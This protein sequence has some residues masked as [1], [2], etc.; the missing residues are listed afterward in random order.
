[1]LTVAPVAISPGTAS[2]PA[3]ALTSLTPT[4]TWSAVT[5]VN[6]YQVRVLN[7]T[8]GVYTLT[9]T[10][11]ATVT[12]Y[13]VPSGMLLPGRLFAW[14]VRDVIGKTP[15]ASSG[16]LNFGTPVPPA[17]VAAPLVGTGSATRPVLSTLRPTLAWSAVANASGYVLHVTDDETGLVITE[18][19]TARDTSYTF[20]TD[21]LVPGH[22]FDWNVRDVIGTATARTASN[23]EHFQL[24][25]LPVPTTLSPGMTG[26]SG[27]ALTTFTPTFTWAP[28]TSVT[29]FSGYLLT[30][31]DRAKGTSV[32]VSLSTSATS[33]TLPAGQLIPGHRYVWNLRLVDGT[34]TGKVAPSQ[35]RYFVAPRVDG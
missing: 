8:D 32:P 7:R 29:G 3:A 35:F 23:T 11:A 33:Y 14:S 19:L 22:R 6:G 31:Y 34:L 18:S 12:Q 4:F 9:V 16:H 30:L 2:G 25:A 26:G 17:P 13:T 1:M 10:V 21:A 20:A 27:E 24:P 5:G 28:V 15:R